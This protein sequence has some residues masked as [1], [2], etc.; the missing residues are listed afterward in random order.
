MATWGVSIFSD[1]ELIYSAK[2]Y[3]SLAFTIRAACKEMKGTPSAWCGIR[4]LHPRNNC[5]DTLVVEIET[6]WRGEIKS[7][8]H[9]Q[10]YRGPGYP[11]CTVRELNPSYFA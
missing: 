10:N 8:E 7:I 3:N 11:C 5:L 2:G 1:E 9:R 6:D 4:R